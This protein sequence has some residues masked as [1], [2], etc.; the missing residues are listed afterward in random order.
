MYPFHSMN[1]RPGKGRS[2]FF[3]FHFRLYHAACFRSNTIC[4]VRFIFLLGFRDF[5]DPLPYAPLP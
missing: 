5:I 1:P 3:D 4:C 2:S